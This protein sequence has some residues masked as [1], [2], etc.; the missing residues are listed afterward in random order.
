[1]RKAFHTGTEVEWDWGNRTASGEVRNTFTSE[2]IRQFNGSK[3]KRRATKN[4]PAY[5][6][7]QKD[8]DRVLK[9]HS[10]IRRPME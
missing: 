4:N 8:G 5:L 7:L 1:M 10:E 9:L 2:V 6:I 3:I